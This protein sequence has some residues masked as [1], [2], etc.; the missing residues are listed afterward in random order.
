VLTS[1]RRYELRI[2]RED[3]QTS[4]EDRE[5]EEESA[6][7]QQTRREE[8]HTRADELKG[9]RRRTRRYRRTNP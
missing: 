6:D 4:S 9:G 7:K 2:P 3:E 1:A 5:A 8:V